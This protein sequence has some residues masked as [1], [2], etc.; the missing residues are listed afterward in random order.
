MTWSPSEFRAT[1]RFALV[2]SLSFFLSEEWFQLWFR[3]RA[4][5]LVVGGGFRMKGSLRH[6]SPV[7]K[8]KCD[9]LGAS[10]DSG[11]S[12]LAFTARPS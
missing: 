5:F 2:L 6:V 8:D 9:R 7:P 3:P 4:A 10:S 1:L 11:C 12:S